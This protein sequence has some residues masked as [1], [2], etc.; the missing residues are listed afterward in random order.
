MTGVISTLYGLI[1]A[2]DALDT[3]R[4]KQTIKNVYQSVLRLESF[5]DNTRDLSRLAS[6]E[7]ELN[8]KRVNLSEL[9]LQRLD[10]CTK[11]YLENKETDIHLW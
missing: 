11:L 6:N 7:T 2:Y 3:D 4:V 1:A 5:D 10:H 8:I 9:V